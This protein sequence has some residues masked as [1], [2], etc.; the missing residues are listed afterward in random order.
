VSFNETINCKRHVQVILRQFFPE[1]KEEEKPMDVVNKTQLLP[2][3]HM[4]TQ[5]LSDVLRD[6]IISSGIWP[7]CSPDLNLSDIFFSGVV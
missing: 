6:R 1:L 5:V 2:T 7:A 4:S 3:L